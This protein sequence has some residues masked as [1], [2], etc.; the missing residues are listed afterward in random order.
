VSKQII[1]EIPASAMPSGHEVRKMTQTRLINPWKNLPE[2]G[3]FVLQQDRSTVE[4]HNEAVTDNY[5]YHL[6]LYPEPYAGR[7]N[8]EVVVLALNPGLSQDDLV[9]HNSEAYQNLWQ[10]NI[11]QSIDD[12]PLFLIHPNLSHA[13]CFKWWSAKLRYLINIFGLQK[14][15]RSILE[16]QLFPYHSKEFKRRKGMLPS[17]S[18]AVQLVRRAM[19]NGSVI[20]LMRSRAIWEEYIPELRD[21]NRLLQIRNPRNPTFSEKN[22]PEIG[23]IVDTI[24]SGGSN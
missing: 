23:T 12:Y 20:V 19:S 24:R 2:S 8:A 18:F 15:A 14:V 3:P 10:G 21:Y 6:E 7:I 1:A 17:Q 22:L 13:P 5:R 16:I 11:N 9:I 4:S